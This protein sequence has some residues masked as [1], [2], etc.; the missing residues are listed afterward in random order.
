MNTFAH[1]VS[2]LL[3][4]A[5]GNTDTRPLFNRRFALPARCQRPTAGWARLG[6]GVPPAVPF[7]ALQQLGEG[8]S[9]SRLTPREGGTLL[10]MNGGSLV[11][12]A[13]I[14]G[15]QMLDTGPQATAAS[16][17][18]ERSAR[19]VQHRQSAKHGC[20]GRRV[21]AYPL[22][23]GRRRR[24]TLLVPCAPRLRQCTT[25]TILLYPLSHKVS[26]ESEGRYNVPCQNSCLRM[27][28]EGA[29]RRQMHPP[30]LF[31]QEI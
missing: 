27:E 9:G 31:M 22:L 23:G 20:R 1:C 12:S 6:Q 26:E 16:T 4:C 30:P 17:A 14:S 3:P 29:I 7:A 10:T 19:R 15:A 11:L 18:D 21:I 24:G 13:C 28:A 8:R 5:V 25:S 2:G